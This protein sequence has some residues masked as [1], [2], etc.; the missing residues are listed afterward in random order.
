MHPSKSSMPVTESGCQQ[1]SN[2]E[3]VLPTKDDF[4]KKISNLN[5]LQPREVDI[6]VLWA[7]ATD[8]NAGNCM[9]IH[10]FIREK[11][12]TVEII[13]SLHQIMDVL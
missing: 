7:G 8:E 5:D 4:I 6:V 1:I 13:A 3:K 10:K 12:E 9:S 11:F 2:A